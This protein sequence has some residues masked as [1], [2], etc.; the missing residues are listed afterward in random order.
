VSGR[1]ASF[2]SEHEPHERPVPPFNVIPEARASEQS[3]TY[4]LRHDEWIPDEFAAR[5]SGM[6]NGER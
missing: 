4:F 5:L 3:G 6:T 2:S 1:R